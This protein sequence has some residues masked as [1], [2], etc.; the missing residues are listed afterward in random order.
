MNQR[1]GKI[2]FWAMFTFFNLTFFP[3]FIVGLLGQPRR[4]FEYAKNSR[5][6]TTSRR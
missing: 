6:G 4:V 1:L 3:L 2:H 5:R